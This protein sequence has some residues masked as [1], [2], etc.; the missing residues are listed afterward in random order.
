[1][2]LEDAKLFKIDIFAFIVDFTSAFSTTDHDKMLWIMYDLGFPTDA[3]DTVKTCMKTLLPKHVW[4]LELPA[5]ELHP[6]VWAA[7]C[8]AA[9]TVMLSV[10]KQLRR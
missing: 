1:M 9:L 7:V 5:T 8:L 3:I 2:S 4:L 6:L 10:S